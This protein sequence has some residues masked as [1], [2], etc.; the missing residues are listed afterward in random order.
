MKKIDTVDGQETPQS[1]VCTDDV[2]QVRNQSVN[3]IQTLIAAIGAMFLG[4]G[5]QMIV[6]DKLEPPVNKFADSYIHTPRRLYRSLRFKSK[7]MCGYKQEGDFLI[8]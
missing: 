1:L 6:L 4:L 8:V 5:G 7:V 2:I 3:M